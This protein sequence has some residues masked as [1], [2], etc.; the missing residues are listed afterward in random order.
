MCI[1]SGWIENQRGYGAKGPREVQQPERQCWNQQ[2]RQRR[3]KAQVV[4]EVLLTAQVQ[5]EG[6]VALQQHLGEENS[7]T[8][9]KDGKG[10]RQRKN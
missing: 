10:R 9:T 8:G 6:S 5:L 1:Q 2:R 7:A 4:S 3:W